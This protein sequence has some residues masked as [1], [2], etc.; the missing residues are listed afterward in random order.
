VRSQINLWLSHPVTKI[1]ISE[2]GKAKESHL[3]RLLSMKV[4][5]TNFADAAM[6]TSK[7]NT[8]DLILNPELLENLLDEV[9][10][11]EVETTEK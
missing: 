10:S 1:L 5:S 11:D 8:L 9:E 6:L 7:I 4:D 3:A 2:L